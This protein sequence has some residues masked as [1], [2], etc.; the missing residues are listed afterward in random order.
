MLIS[1]FFYFFFCEDFV[2]CLNS[3]FFLKV[4]SH[5]VKKVSG[6]YEGSYIDA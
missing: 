2:N 1:R 3:D 4:L 5:F 6:F